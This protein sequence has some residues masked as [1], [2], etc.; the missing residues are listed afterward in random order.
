MD[1]KIGHLLFSGASLDTISDSV[2]LTG[3]HFLA[4][5]FGVILCVYV[6]QLMMAGAIQFHD[7]CVI[8]YHVRRTALML[9][10]LAMCWALTYSSNKGWQP[11]PPDVLIVI[12]IDLMLAAGVI[13]ALRRKRAMG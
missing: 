8:A 7:D 4:C 13:V 3:V 5:L 11:W 10:A 12:S 1:N 9:L 2:D 6:M